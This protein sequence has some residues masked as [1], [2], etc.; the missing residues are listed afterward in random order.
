MFVRRIS[1]PVIK[2]CSATIRCPLKFR[3]LN[4]TPERRAVDVD[5]RNRKAI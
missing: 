3:S 1:S 4:E 2:D 5:D